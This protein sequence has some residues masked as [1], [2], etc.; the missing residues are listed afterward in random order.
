MA[1][2]AP[3]HY[4]DPEF[5]A[6]MGTLA[7]QARLVTE[8]FVSGLHRSPFFGFNI[9][10]A[11][12]REYTPGD[13]IRYIDW[14]TYART[15][16]FHIKLFEEET[17][18]RIYLL[19]DASGSMGYR[20]GKSTVTKLDY[21]KCLAASLAF[22]GLKQK[23]AMGMAMFREDVATFLPPS[24]RLS[25]LKEA[26]T[27]LESTVPEAGTDVLSCFEQVSD[28]LRKRGL[29]VLISDLWDSPER[30]MEGI[31]H[32]RHMKHEAMVLHVLDSMERT[33][34]V[35]GERLYVDMET[36]ETMPVNPLEIAEAYNK[37]M[38]ERIRGFRAYFREHSV[39]YAVFDTSTSYGQALAA[40][41]R[42]RRS[43]G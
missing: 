39:D 33:L 42:K 35:P 11:E 21:G 34:A 29:V 22:L 28:Q 25:H 10:F 5:V 17:N 38:Q 3:E 43:V 41:L 31:L 16:K 18:M 23:D 2:T 7:L 6:Q 14:K 36:G 37:A 4:L 1:S 15:E 32:L 9:E 12:H 40:F 19:L 26:V 13:E 8:G 30:V 27:L 24:S 20:H